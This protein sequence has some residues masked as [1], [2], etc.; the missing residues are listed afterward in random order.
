MR[1]CPSHHIRDDLKLGSFNIS[2]DDHPE[3]GCGAW[4]SACKNIT[5]IINNGICINTWVW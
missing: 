4:K 5:V 3:M 2:F 1:V